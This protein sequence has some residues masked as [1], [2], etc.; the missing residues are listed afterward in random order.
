MNRAQ[1]ILE[2]LELFG[3]R[4]GLDTTRPLLA[5]LG[6]PQSHVP[7]VLVAGTNGKGSTAT[8]LAAMACA[9]GY[10]TGLYTS[11]HLEAVE[12][13]LRIDGRAVDGEQLGRLLTSVIEA[14]E[15]A[16]AAPP[17]YFEA[18]TA[19]AWVW[20]AESRVD[21]AVMEVGMGGRLDATNAGNPILSVITPIGLDHTK[22]LGES[23]PAIAREKAG[24]LRAAVPAVSWPGSALVEETL[25][26]AANQ[27]GAVLLLAPR[28]VRDLLSQPRELAGQHVELCT[29]ADHYQIDL[30][31]PGHHQ[32]ENLAL[33]VLAAETLAAQGFD[34]LDGA[35]IRAGAE[36]CRWP[37]RLEHVVCPPPHAGR[38]L[39]LDA[40]HN[41]LGIDALMRFLAHR[42]QI[43]PC[44]DDRGFDL[45]F[46]AFANKN[47][48][49]MLAA[50]A[51]RA[52][53]VILTS[54]QGRRAYS[55]RELAR[56]V[57][58]R[59]AILE[60]QPSRA[61]SIALAGEGLLVV[62]GSLYLVGEVRGLLRQQLGVPPSPV[63][64][65]FSPQVATAPA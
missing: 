12:E 38:D 44:G 2:R 4:L 26:D 56:W 58:D 27:A 64:S 37:G 28:E 57:P 7:T 13:R 33:A 10:R 52:R 51:G 3:V 55:P 61:L 1:S 49:G 39:L 21:L 46:G 23:L 14:G 42:P 18:L 40:A 19:A 15:E 53:R 59:T 20:F 54:P 43:D 30:P 32:A 8:L 62:T 34:R 35:A 41:P 47:A 16:L 36:G 50:L 29:P 6:N 31:L 63:E 60:A 45:L 24:I 17:T 5:T 11:P 22:H 65:I 48:E 9:A 25:I